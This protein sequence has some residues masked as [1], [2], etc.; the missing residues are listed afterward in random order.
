[1]PS[2]KLTKRL[3][4]GTAPPTKALELW[5][6]V[7][8]G[9]LVKIT[10]AG[11]RVFMVFYRTA[12]GTKRK[13]RLGSTH[14]LTL[15]QAREAARQL[16]ST[17]ARGVDPSAE[18]Q[19][20]R[21]APDVNELCTRYLRDVAEPHHKPSTL[22]QHQRMVAKHIQP[23]LG[24]LKVATVARAEI[25]ALHN[26]LRATPTE[27]NRMLALASVIFNQA[28][29]WDMRAEG[30]NPARGIKRFRETRRERLLS[31]AE[32]ARLLQAGPTLAIRLLF[33]TGCRA[34]EIL[35]LRWEWI[36]REASV[37]KWPDSKTGPLVKPLTDELRR[38]LTPSAPDGLV[39][40]D[41]TLSKLD[42]AWRRLLL[43]AE[44]TPCGLHAIRHRAVTEIANAGLPLQVAMSLTGHRTAATFLRYC[45]TDRAQTLAAA[46]L[47]AARRL[48]GTG[49]A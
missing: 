19:Q 39:F 10:P 35:T 44:V 48:G 31:D 26:R 33:A 47:V 49:E 20:L 41:L 2:V 5:D 27:V 7:Q 22:K 9:L 4:D 32:V 36:D 18:R 15:A 45:H 3:I 42:K 17:V 14:Q 21:R 24:T 40:P 16:L 6:T 25:I 28:E 1:M 11:N 23:G 37:I 13:P 8:R 12:D 30:T 43:Q 34:G 29:R 38:L 46:E